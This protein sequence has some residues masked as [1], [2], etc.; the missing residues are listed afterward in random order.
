M[1]R[2]Y[3]IPTFAQP[4]DPLSTRMDSGAVRI[5][6]RLVQDLP[7]DQIQLN[8]YPLATQPNFRSRHGR[9]AN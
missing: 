5:V 6:T 8:V 1:L 2:E 7:V 4:D 9:R 3:D